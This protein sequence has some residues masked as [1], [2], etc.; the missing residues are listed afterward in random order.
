MCVMEQ[1][2]VRDIRQNIS[3]FLRRVK[4]GEAFTVTE[5]GLPVALLVPVPA[6]SDDRL[7]DLVAAGHVLAAPDRG[8]GL[9]PRAG[10]PLGRPSATQALLDERRA[11]ER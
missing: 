10:T 9:P 4:A 3:V 5:H 7:A 8:G 2:G 1:V 6:D 11:D